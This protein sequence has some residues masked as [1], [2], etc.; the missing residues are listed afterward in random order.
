[1]SSGERFCLVVGRGD[2]WYGQVKEMPQNRS[3]RVD[4]RVHPIPAEG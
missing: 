4:H 3:P 1:M 2:I